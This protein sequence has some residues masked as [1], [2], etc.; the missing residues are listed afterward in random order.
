MPCSECGAK[1]GHMSGCPLLETTPGKG[2]GMGGPGKKRGAQREVPP[3]D[4][5]KCPPHDPVLVKGRKSKRGFYTCG[6][7]SKYLGM[8]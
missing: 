8:E 7:C 4:P 6:K 1:R 3:Q 2:R 5:R